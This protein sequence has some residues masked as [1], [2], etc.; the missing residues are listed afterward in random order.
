MVLRPGRFLVVAIAL[1]PPVMCRADNAR[2]FVQ[3]AVD[4]ELAKDQSDHSLWIYFDSDR[5]DGRS[6]EQWVADTRDGSLHRVVKINDQPVPPGQQRQKL[7][8]FLQDTSAQAKQRKSSQHDD[9]QATELLHLLPQAFVWTREG[10]KDNCTLLHFKPD[11]N[12]QPPDFQARVFAAMEGD[13]AVDNSQHRIASLRGRLVHDVKILGG[14]VASLYSGDLADHGD[15]RAHRGACAAV[16]DH[17]RTG[18]RGEDRVQGTAGE[19][20]HAAGGGGIDGGAEVRF[21]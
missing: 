20:D 4:N 12:F 21:T 6:V 9:Q 8:S 16:Q 11:P 2:Q 7:E 15:A 1:L 17:L 14:L 18:R 19:Y 10:E 13:M 5:K 3:Q